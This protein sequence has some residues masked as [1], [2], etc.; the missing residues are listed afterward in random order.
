MSV[1][2][3]KARKGD[4][5]RFRC[6]G[7]AVIAEIHPTGTAANSYRARFDIS[8][9][10]YFYSPA[11]LWTRTDTTVF[12]IIAIE[13]APFDWKDVRPGMAFLYKSKPW[14][15]AGECLYVDGNALCMRK[16]SCDC[17]PLYDGLSKNLMTR[18]PEHDIEVTP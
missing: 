12:D 13:P 4:K 9:I 16:F 10:D 1:D 7:G 2:L 8:E 15:Y 14:V 3:S 17:E 6:G 18:A 5:V 11:G